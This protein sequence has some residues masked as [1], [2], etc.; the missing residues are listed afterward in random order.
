MGIYTDVQFN[1]TLFI[2]LGEKYCIIFLKFPPLHKIIAS[3]IEEAIFKKSCM[4]TYINLISKYE[5]H[6]YISIANNCTALYAFLHSVRSRL[7]S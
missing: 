3:H 7:G 1:M 6:C 4:V 2:F 5:V